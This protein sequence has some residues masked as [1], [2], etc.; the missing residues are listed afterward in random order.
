MPMTGKHQAAYEAWT[1][2][3]LCGKKPCDCNGM[4]LTVDQITSYFSLL[5]KKQKDAG[6]GKAAEKAAEQDGMI[7]EL[8]ARHQ[9][10]E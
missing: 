7:A 4:L 1:G 5:A 10:E 3:E 9:E 2:C 6:K 8:E